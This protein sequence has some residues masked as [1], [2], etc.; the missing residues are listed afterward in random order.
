MHPVLGDDRH[1]REARLEQ[2]DR[3]VLHLAGGIRLRMEIADLLELERALVGRRR[4]DAASEE[5]RRVGAAEDARGSLVL[6]GP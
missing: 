4:I 3:A 2:R 6:P 1:H 5:E